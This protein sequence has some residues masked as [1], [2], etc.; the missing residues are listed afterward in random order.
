MPCLKAGTLHMKDY[1]VKG[2]PSPSAPRLPLSDGML[3]AEA[4]NTITH[5][6]R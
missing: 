3:F 4:S 1:N 5:Q 6:I 2:N